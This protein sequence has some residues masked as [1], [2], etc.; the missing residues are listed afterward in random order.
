M[1][2][3]IMKRG[4]WLGQT[5]MIFPNGGFSKLTESGLKIVGK[6]VGHISHAGPLAEAAIE[7]S[8]KLQ[9]KIHGALVGGVSVAGVLYLFDDHLEFEPNLPKALVPLYKGIEKVTLD[10]SQ[11]ISVEH[12]RLSKVFNIV[13]LTLQTGTCR[14]QELFEKGCREIADTIKEQLA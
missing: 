1:S 8:G 2:T 3:L 6:V 14:I 4:G 9:F 13:E 11:V 12:K 5:F 10:Y 7:H